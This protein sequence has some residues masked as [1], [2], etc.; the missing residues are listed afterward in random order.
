[1]ARRMGYYNLSRRIDDFNEQTLNRLSERLDQFDAW[2]DTW[3]TGL[4]PSDEDH[5][6][7]RETT[8]ETGIFKNE[9]IIE[10]RNRAAQVASMTYIRDEIFKFAI[11]GIIS[12]GIIFFGAFLFMKSN[13]K[14]EV[15]KPPVVYEQTTQDDKYGQRNV[16]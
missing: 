7:N 10:Q 12:L 13:D 8:F 9:E 1:M 6:F 2:D 14:K 11:A 15:V 3:D 16:Y 5:Y 4:S